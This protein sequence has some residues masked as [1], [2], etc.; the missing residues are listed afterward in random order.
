MSNFNTYFPIDK[1]PLN[2]KILKEVTTNAFGIPTLENASFEIES[3]GKR[4]YLVM[5]LEFAPR[6]T[7]LSWASRV[8]NAQKYKDHTVIILTHSYL[9]A[10]NEH[11]I[12]ENYQVKDANYGAAMFKKL[13]QPANNIRMV[14]SGHI[15]APDDDKAHIA[16][17]TDK[18]AGGRNIQQ[19]TFN[20]QALG[21]GWMGNGGD[22]WLRILEFLPGDE[23]IK[24]KTFSPLF[25]I[26]PKTQHLAWRTKDYDE[27]TIDLN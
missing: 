22:G 14:V 11:I 12:R 23:I 16:F 4:K 3:P 15:G 17:R 24:V 13:I 26:S 9:S 18:N 7:V 5:N 20:A 10:K 6:D 1:N 27:F 21:G 25:A 19:M 2:Q 8:V